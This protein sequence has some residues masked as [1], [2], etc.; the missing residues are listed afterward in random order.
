MIVQV[1]KQFHLNGSLNLHAPHNKLRLIPDT[2]RSHL[3]VEIT[4]MT[5]QKPPDCSCS[6]LISE[7]LYPPANILVTTVSVSQDAGIFF[8]L[9]IRA[10][11]LFLLKLSI[12][13]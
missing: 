13:M 6:K 10:A 9:N 11:S 3:P 7:H 2:Y 4:N 5:F 1:L 8:A 12:I